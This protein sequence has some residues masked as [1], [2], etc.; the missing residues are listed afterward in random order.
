M[1]WVGGHIL[2]VNS[3]EVGW[4]WPYD[5]VH[6]WEE[7]VHDAVPAAWAAS[8]GWLLN[9]AV[10]AVVGLVV[11]GIVV[12]VVHLLPRRRAALRPRSRIPPVR[13]PPS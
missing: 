6:H 7:A 5:T 9:T 10:S 11:G 4:H 2:L 3:A 13:R 1:L 8:L 12:A